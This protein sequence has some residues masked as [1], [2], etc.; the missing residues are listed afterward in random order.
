[1]R[2]LAPNNESEFLSMRASIKLGRAQEMAY[3][4]PDPAFGKEGKRSRVV[5]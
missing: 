2:S 3:A 1:M 4:T 5:P